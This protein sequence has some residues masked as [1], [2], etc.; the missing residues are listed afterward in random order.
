MTY[1]ENYYYL[2]LFLTSNLT[3][4]KFVYVRFYYVLNF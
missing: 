2:F 3:T 1:N 4:A